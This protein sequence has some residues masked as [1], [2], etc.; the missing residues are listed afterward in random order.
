MYKVHYRIIFILM[1]LLLGNR[2][3][4]QSYTE[5]TGQWVNVN[6]SSEHLTLS[7]NG[8]FRLITHDVFNNEYGRHGGRWLYRTR[9]K[10]KL[11]L[12]FPDHLP[13]RFYKVK[14]RGALG[15]TLNERKGHVVYARRALQPGELLP[16]IGN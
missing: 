4:G 1:L 7:T 13:K 12:F 15:Y 10:K 16:K 11:F 8:E 5:I 2:A 3:L 14:L 9:M 6:D